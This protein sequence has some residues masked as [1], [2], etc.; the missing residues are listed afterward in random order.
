MVA[1]DKQLFTPADEMIQ[2][3]LNILGDDQPKQHTEMT[4]QTSELSGA[5]EPP[6]EQGNEN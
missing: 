6:R 5:T 1:Q 4:E 2:P 3:T